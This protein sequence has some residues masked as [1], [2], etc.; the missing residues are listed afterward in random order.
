MVDRQNKVKEL[1][2]QDKPLAEILEQFNENESRL[3][4]SIYKEI[5]E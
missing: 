4:T 5:S 3:V 2:S 1:V